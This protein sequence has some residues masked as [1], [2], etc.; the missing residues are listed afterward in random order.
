MPYAVFCF[1][2]PSPQYLWGVRT[3]SLPL[4]L[5]ISRR[6]VPLF[7]ACG[8]TMWCVVVKTWHVIRVHFCA[9][10]CDAACA[11]C[12]CSASHPLY[13]IQACCGIGFSCNL[14]STQSRSAREQQR[15][16]HWLEWDSS[17]PNTNTTF[18]MHMRIHLLVVTQSL[19]HS[20]TQSVSLPFTELTAKPDTHYQGEISTHMY[21]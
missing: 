20:V 16:V 19:C 17:I 5:C 9:V 1:F 15:S 21:P 14:T 18:R 10:L 7:I 3:L 11:V 8:A 12:V 13:I 2:W 4:P 6:T